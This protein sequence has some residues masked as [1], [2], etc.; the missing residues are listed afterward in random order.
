MASSR[1]THPLNMCVYKAHGYN[2]ILVICPILWRS[3]LRL[4]TGAVDRLSHRKRRETKQ[5]AA[6]KQS[7]VRQSNQLLHSFSL[8]PMRHPVY[9][10]G[11]VLRLR[12]KAIPLNWPIFVVQ[13][14]WPFRWE[15]LYCTWNRFKV[16]LKLCI[17]RDRPL[18]PHPSSLTHSIHLD[19]PL[20]GVA[21]AVSAKSRK[22]DSWRRNSLGTVAASEA[23]EVSSGTHL[24]TAISHCQFLLPGWGIPR[25]NS[26]FLLPFLDLLVSSTFPLA[27][28]FHSDWKVGCPCFK[29]LKR[30]SLELCMGDTLL[31]DEPRMQCVTL[32]MSSFPQK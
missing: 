10:P 4:F 20:T 27:S 9:W 12:Y 5:H 26:P 22:K 1:T 31:L 29:P 28:S 32:I 13:N 16:R 23:V 19:S 2:A 7:Q 8:F 24:G 15:A 25:S 21:S 30:E 17:T 3:L 6:A 14:C 11:I 18:C